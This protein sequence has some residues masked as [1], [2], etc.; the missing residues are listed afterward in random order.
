MQEPPTLKEV[1]H[2]AQV[3]L[4]T[5]SLVL[6][7][8]PGTRIAAATRRRVWQAARDLNYRVR[9]AQNRIALHFLAAGG[10]QRPGPYEQLP[11]FA[12]AQQEAQRRGALL[13][14]AFM[15]WTA[16]E[17]VACL[18][19][20]ATGE[21]HG[22]L[23][24]SRFTPEAQARLAELRI[25]AVR[26]GSHQ[27]NL[28]LTSVHSDNAQGIALLM[29]HLAALGHRRIAFCGGRP[30]MFYEDERHQAYQAQH[31]R[32]AGAAPLPEWTHWDDSRDQLADW[33]ERL[34]RLPAPQRPTAILADKERI[35]RQVLESLQRLGWRVPEQLSLVVFDDPCV[36]DPRWP[37]VTCIRRP[38][39]AIASVAVARL[40][41]EAAR[42]DLPSVRIVLPVEL[43]VRNSSGPP[44]GDERGVR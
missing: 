5:A 1:A 29:D 24:A 40:L 14:I 26:V 17:Q 22:L 43:I 10:A 20:L 34:W 23:I 44:P 15:G 38:V 12:A 19:A 28:G 33:L 8:R 32:L 3:S 42:R 4:T 30:E 2:R 16:G 25:P 13:H 41:E 18:E 35:A 37:P 6:N 36:Q 39:E 11:A 31:L 7:D 9:P 21:T 27:W